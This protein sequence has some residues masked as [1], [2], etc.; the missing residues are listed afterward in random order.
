[1]TREGRNCSLFCS[2][3]GRQRGRVQRKD[4]KTSSV[5]QGRFSNLNP[6]N[7]QT[8]RLQRGQHWGNEE[9]SRERWDRKTTTIWHWNEEPDMRLNS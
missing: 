9:A 2:Q 4:P 3:K 6:L 1:M 8:R 5:Q 7:K